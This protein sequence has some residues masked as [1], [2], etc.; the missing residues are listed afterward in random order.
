[1]D[2][3]TTAIELPE[4][5]DASQYD[6]IPYARHNLFEDSNPELETMA[7]DAIRSALEVKLG[8]PVVSRDTINQRFGLKKLGY[9]SDHILSG[10][11]LV[12]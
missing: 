1:M 11:V 7:R 3:S 2:I 12:R 4:N 9:T 6:S 5:F 10:K 8:K